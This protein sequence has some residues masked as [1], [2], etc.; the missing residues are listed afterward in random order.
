MARSSGIRTIIESMSV[1]STSRSVQQIFRYPRM[2]KVPRATPML[3]TF[4]P[5]TSPMLTA[6][7]PCMIENMATI[8]S[9]VEV[10][11]A[12]IMKPADTSLKP[13]ISTSRS[14]DF[15][16]KWLADAK[17][18]REAMRIR[19][20]IPVFSIMLFNHPKRILI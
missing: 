20:W 15:M 3:N 9:G 16:A 10:K 6:A 13:V 5:S 12:S 2:P 17:P 11:T 7:F 19:I 4:D 8:I 14:I 1:N 18:S